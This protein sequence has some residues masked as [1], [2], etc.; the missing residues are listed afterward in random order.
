MARPMTIEGKVRRAKAEAKAKGFPI[1][2][3]RAEAAQV[4][5]VT[6]ASFATYAHVGKIPTDGDL[7]VRVQT[8]KLA[9][10]RPARRWH[11]DDLIR[12]R[13]HRCEP[14]GRVQSDVHVA[15]AA[16]VAAD[17]SATM[18]DIAAKLDVHQRTVSRHLTGK[19]ACASAA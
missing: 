16:A 10:Q 14:K 3:S 12:L 13:V 19:C 1:W 11:R 4:M 18:R 5:G 9:G 2:L 7:A 6:V 15:V 8:V 17:A